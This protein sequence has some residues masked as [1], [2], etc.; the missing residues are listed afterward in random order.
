MKKLLYLFIAGTFLISCS[1][2]DDSNLDPI[3]GKWK[4][5]SISLDGKEISIGDECDQKSTLTFLE[6]GS[7]EDVF[8]LDNGYGE[9]NKTKGKSTWKNI[10]NSTYIFNEFETKLEFLNNNNSYTIT[11]NVKNLDNE[12]LSSISTY[13]RI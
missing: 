7:S 8:Y 2:N 10:G 4:L 12:E 3:I 13:S 5:A 6:N 11:I 9:C 1:S